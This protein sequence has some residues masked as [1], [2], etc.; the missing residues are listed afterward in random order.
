VREFVELQS[1][2]DDDR[3]ARLQL[4]ANCTPRLGA[5]PSIARPG[6]LTV[7]IDCE[8]SVVPTTTLESD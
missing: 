7:Q 8:P 6:R 4:P 2:S 5:S 3:R 1:L